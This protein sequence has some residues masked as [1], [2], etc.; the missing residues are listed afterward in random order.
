MLSFILVSFFTGSQTFAVATHWLISHRRSKRSIKMIRY[1][2]TSWPAT[3]TRLKN[4]G[5]FDAIHFAAYL[6]NFCAQYYAKYRRLR[7]DSWD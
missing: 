6:S 7:T 1:S 2:F 3:V 4:I 5:K